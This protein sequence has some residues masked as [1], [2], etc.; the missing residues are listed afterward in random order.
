MFG[1]G[2]YF[3]LVGYLCDRTY[4]QINSSASGCGDFMAGLLCRVL[5]CG[6][7]GAGAT[8]RAGECV[9]FGVVAILSLPPLNGIKI[10]QI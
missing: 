8:V 4:R 3:C 10:C 2:E 6:C 1:A 9:G 5:C 7:V